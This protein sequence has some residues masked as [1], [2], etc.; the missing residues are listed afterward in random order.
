P[1]VALSRRD[2]VHFCS[3]KRDDSSGLEWSRVYPFAMRRRD[4]LKA[5]AGI[6]F[7]AG[8]RTRT[9]AATAHAN[10]IRRV[11]PGDPGS[12]SVAQWDELRRQTSGRL[13]AV[14]SPLED[15]RSAAS[16]GSACRDVFKEL[17][18]P[19]FIGD[20]VGLTQTTGWV[21]AWTFRSSVYAVAA[22]TT[23]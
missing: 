17:K 14:R 4:V 8:L 11:R 21:D 15:C 3:L 23:A 13:I 6:P 5:V 9:G 7:L 12:P 19:Y 16:D 1:H 20:Q 18:N 10:P 2:R 22:E